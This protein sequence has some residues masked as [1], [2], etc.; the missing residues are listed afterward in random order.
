MS[1]RPDQRASGDQDRAAPA[2][3]IEAVA[4]KLVALVEEFEA[5]ISEGQVPPEFT[6]RLAQLRRSA[7]RLIED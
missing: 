2:S 4:N 6:V 1:T 7:D 5:A 3:E